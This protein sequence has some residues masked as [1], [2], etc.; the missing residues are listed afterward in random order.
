MH[1]LDFYRVL[2]YK[3]TLDATLEMM[4]GLDFCRVPVSSR[5]TRMLSTPGLLLMSDLDVHR[6]SCVVRGALCVCQVVLSA[7]PRL[8]T[9]T[10]IEAD[11]LF[12][13]LAFGGVF[14]NL[15]GVLFFL[16]AG[17]DGHDHFH[18]GGFLSA[19][20][21]S[22]DHGWVTVMTGGTCSG[23]C[24]CFFWYGVG[25]AR[26]CRNLPLCFFQ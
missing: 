7:V 6:L 20:S 10:E 1:N 11:R 17:G 4:N 19:H 22:H 23:Y 13:G 15:A 25:E 8:I 21:H 5:S 26:S 2:F 9:P 3:I 14:V 12:I 18:A 24:P 16:A